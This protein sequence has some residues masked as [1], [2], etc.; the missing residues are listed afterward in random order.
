MSWPQ[1]RHSGW[2]IDLNDGW[3]RTPDEMYEINVEFDHNGFPVF[4]YGNGLSSS[5]NAPTYVISRI[6]ADEDRLSIK[7][8]AT[9]DTKMSNLIELHG[10]LGHPN[11]KQMEGLLRLQDKTLLKLKY[12]RDELPR[13]LN[14][15]ECVGC[16]KGGGR[17]KPT[18]ALQTTTEAVPGRS[19]MGD[20]SGPYR[21]AGITGAIYFLLIH[22]GK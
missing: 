3:L 6:G 2:S 17:R 18:H 14:V 15:P 12:A 9:M 5:A 4:D 16:I 20:L 13:D 1:L 21:I 11:A 10:S 8:S 22:H 19:A 7:R